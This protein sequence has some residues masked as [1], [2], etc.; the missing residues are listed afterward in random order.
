[1][2]SVWVDDESRCSPPLRARSMVSRPIVVRGEIQGVQ[3]FGR[4]TGDDRH[5]TSNDGRSCDQRKIE[6]R[7]RFRHFG[8]AEQTNL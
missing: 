5:S 4:R 8:T 2:N 1:W 7:H 3:W 6:R